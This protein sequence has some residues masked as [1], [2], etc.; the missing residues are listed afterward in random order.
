MTQIIDISV[1]IGSG[2]ITWPGDPAVEIH[3]TRSL[4]NGD[5]ANVSQIQFG[6]HTGTHVDPPFH[7]VED[8]STVENLPLEVLVGE[9]VVADL[10]HVEDSVQPDDLEA[11][12][13]APGVERLLLKTRNS[14][15]WQGP[16]EFP[17]HYVALSPEGAA[18]AVQR[19]IR[20]V[21]IDFL[22]IERRKTPGHPTHNTLLRAGVV[23]IEGLNLSGVEPGQ[24]RLACLPLKILG[25]DGA[26]ARAVLIQ[27]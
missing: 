9:A 22:S 20:L 1:A 6:S 11:L 12:G 26:P 3:P 18:W 10:G 14:D 7:F 27:G 23:I 19:G 24:Y 8:G 4:S 2:M 13:L 25:G 5:S 16:A 17:A 15:I 21:G